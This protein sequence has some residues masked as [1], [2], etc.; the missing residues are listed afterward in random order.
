[1]PVGLSVALDRDVAGTDPE[2]FEGHAL[3][4]AR[5]ELY[6]AAEEADLRPLD[7]YVS[8]SPDEAEILAADLNFDADVD[9]AAP[10][11]W[12]SA[13]QGLALVEA[14]EAAVKA[15]PD[16]YADPDTVLIELRSLREILAR[17]VAARARFRLAVAY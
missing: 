15:A 9:T 3:N 1:M 13:D 2:L 12:F 7:E 17:A 14:L 6:E 8:L 4:A 10:A 11:G 5:W 16:E